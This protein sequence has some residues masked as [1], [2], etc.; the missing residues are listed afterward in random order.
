MKDLHTNTK[1]TIETPEQKEPNSLGSVPTEFT[2][3][4]GLYTFRDMLQIARLNNSGTVISEDAQVT[5]DTHRPAAC[6][7]ECLIL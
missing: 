5:G 6:S 2:E 1:T 4:K 7:C 3:S